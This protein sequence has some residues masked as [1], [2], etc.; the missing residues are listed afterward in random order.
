MHTLEIEFFKLT[1]KKP[2]G[3]SIQHI[4]TAAVN[5]YIPQLL[6][7]VSAE[8]CCWLLKPLLFKHTQPEELQTKCAQ[9]T[10]ERKC[11]FIAMKHSWWL[12]V[13]CLRGDKHR[14]WRRHF[15]CNVF[16]QKAMKNG[17][18]GLDS[19]PHQKWRFPLG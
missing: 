15:T 17:R 3:R 14:P 7:S 16:Q 11:T 19:S 12:H 1:G 10:S 5:I 9:A 8:A 4:V 2:R 6:T 18:G 13:L